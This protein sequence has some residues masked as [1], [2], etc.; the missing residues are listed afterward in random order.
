[1]NPRRTNLPVC[2]SWSH[3]VACATSRIL[4]GAV[5]LVLS[6]ASGLA[7]GTNTNAVATPA[8][9]PPAQG[10]MNFDKDIRP[11]FEQS[12]FRCHG[13]EKPKSHFR[14]LTRDSALKGGDDNTDDIIP[15]DSLH[16][17]LI[18]YVARVDPDI[19]MPP[20]GKGEPLTPEQIGRLRAWI[21]QGAAWSAT[22]AFV[23]QSAA[24]VTPAF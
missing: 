15:G 3:P 20:E 9:P 4:L 6:A 13:Q 21:D 16:S 7:A 10:T 2:P 17:K 24:S 18:R 19:A 5:G 23:P 8:L 12:C 11:I 22:N 1:M 14:L